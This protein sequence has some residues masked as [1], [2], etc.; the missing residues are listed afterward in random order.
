[1]RRYVPLRFDIVVCLLIAFAISLG[2]AKLAGLALPA[3]YGRYVEENT[4]AQDAVGGPA[5]EDVFRAQSVEDL[6]SH[7]TFTVVS[8]GI[9]YYNNGSA[10]FGEKVAEELMLPSGEFV[11]AIINGQNIQWTEGEDYF[12]SDH[13]LPVGR[14]VFEDLTAKPDFLE[15]IQGRAPLSRTDF[16][17]D[18]AGTGGVV[19]QEEYNDRW[20]G[21]VQL[22]VIVVC[23]PLIHSL[24]A[25]LGLFP[26][27]FVPKS[28]R[29]RKSEWD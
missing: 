20:T 4:I 12:T 14:V 15:Q 21:V 19:D 23:F 17:V 5:G 3:L 11:M 1:M 8:P 6:L 2:T 27:F 10:M 28:I 29:N 13:I 9:K 7:D 22:A 16:Y 18:M 26:F 25:H 24:G